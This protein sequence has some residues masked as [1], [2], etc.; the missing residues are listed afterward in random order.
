MEKS[1]LP[2]QNKCG[3]HWH[4]FKTRR[5]TKH[6]REDADKTITRCYNCL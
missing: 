6:Y 2:T 4:L 3:I 5:T 1:P